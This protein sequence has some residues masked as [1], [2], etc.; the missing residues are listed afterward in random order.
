MAFRLFVVL[1]VCVVAL[2]I[3]SGAPHFEHSFSGFQ[4]YAHHFGKVYSSVEEHNTR[5]AAFLQSAQRID[6][7]N[8]EHLK[9]TGRDEKIFG[10]TKFSD[11]TPE[12]FKSYYLNYKR[13]ARPTQPRHSTI[14]V[15][16]T[17]K[18]LKDSVD[19]RNEGA[20]TPVKNQ[21]QCGG[22]WA[23]ST[24]EAIESQFFMSTGKL[25][26]LSVQ[27]IISC[28][29]NDAGC[30]GG[31]PPTAYQYVEGAGGLELD[32]TYPFSSGNGNNGT[33]QVNNGSLVVSV[34]SFNFAVPECTSGSCSNQD[35]TALANALAQV[36]PMSIC[37]DA[38]PWQDYT[39]GVMS[40]GCPGAANDLDHCVQLVGYD[41]SASPPYW[42]VR[43]QW[44]TSWG[45]DGYIRLEYNHGNVC[46]VADEASY[47][48][49]ACVPGS[50]C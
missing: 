3:V 50:T 5:Y 31:D 16:A 27:Q 24:T 35:E 14:E 11:L 23:F 10:F 39:G 22:C 43:N 41:T 45:E 12:E 25:L 26:E 30:S 44:G 4:R 48:V 2:T 36:G 7:K 9:A 46:G 15:A 34:S 13:S 21:E 28:D 6:E 19:W 8:E 47:P 29:T 42:I 33:C 40:S 38:T 37:I 17:S 32:S 49:T 1:S 18:L 20:V